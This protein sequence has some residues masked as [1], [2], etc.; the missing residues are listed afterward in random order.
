M[1]HVVL[2]RGGHASRVD[3]D[4]TL[5]A[6]LAGARCECDREAALPEQRRQAFVVADL[7]IPLGG[8]AQ[9]LLAR[10]FNDDQLDPTIALELQDYGPFKLERCREEGPGRHQLAEDG[11]QCRRI[12]MPLD[13]SSPRRIEVRDF[14][15]DRG[16]LEKESLET[17]VHGV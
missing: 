14:T 5:I 17:V 15:A 9:G 13:H 1:P 11:P 16:M 2:E 3:L 8:C 6:L 12:L 4:H 7:A 10:A